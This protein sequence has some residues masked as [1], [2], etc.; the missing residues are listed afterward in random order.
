MEKS[1]LKPDISCNACKKSKADE[2]VDCEEGGINARKIGWFY[3]RM[4]PDEGDA[5]QNE[6][7]PVN[8]G[9]MRR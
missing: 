5:D 1:R 3:Q 2:T 6:S 4:F 8:G 7:D 9:K